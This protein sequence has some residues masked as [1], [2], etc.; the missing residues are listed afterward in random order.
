M[1]DCNASG[2]PPEALE[3]GTIASLTV[4]LH[5]AD[6]TSLFL[7]IW[8]SGVCCRAGANSGVNS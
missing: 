3:G 7:G 2:T 5:G 1:Y 8:G 4:V 6:R